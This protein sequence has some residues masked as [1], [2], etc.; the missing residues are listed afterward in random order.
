MTHTLDMSPRWSATGRRLVLAFGTI[1]VLFAAA[2][3]VEVVSLRRITDAQTDH[4]AF[5]QHLVPLM[6]HHEQSEEDVA[7]MVAECA[8]LP[9]GALT[10]I[11]FDQSLQ[12]Y[13]QLLP[14]IDVPTLICWG[15]HDALL[16]VSGAPYMLENIPGA[17]VRLV[18]RGIKV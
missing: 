15:R 12:D 18:H 16:P 5:L 9:V 4:M 8:R 3:A 7:W 10:A 13:R 6:F 11:L 14:T 17:Q 1:L 2:L